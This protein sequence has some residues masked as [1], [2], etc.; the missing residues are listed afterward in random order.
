MSIMR[1]S[2]NKVKSTEE[3]NMFMKMEIFT[4]VYLMKT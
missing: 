4:R 2:S 3:A 1:V